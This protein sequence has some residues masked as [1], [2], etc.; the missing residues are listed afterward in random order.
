MNALKSIKNVWKCT[1]LAEKNE[2]EIIYLCHKLHIHFSGR[3]VKSQNTQTISEILAIDDTLSQQIG[4][5]KT[6]VWTLYILHMFF[7]NFTFN[8]KNS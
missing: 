8:M 7:E 1:P 3:A 5:F 2:F 4:M 6:K